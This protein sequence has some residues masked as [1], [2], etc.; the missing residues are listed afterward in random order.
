[1]SR[2]KGMSRDEKLQAIQD[3]MMETKDIYSLKDLEKELPKKKGISAMTVKDI[4]QEACE[5]DLVSFEKI[6]SGNY[7]WCFP[8]EALNRR[9]VVE[10]KYMEKIDALEK[11]IQELEKEIGEL[12]PGRED[13]SERT[14]LDEE[15][16]DFSRKISEVKRES[17]KYEKLNP[18][19]IRKQKEQTIVAKDAANRWTDNIFTIRSWVVKNFCMESSTFNQQFEIPD[20]FDYVE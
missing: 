12:E 5:N 4:L 1:M 7:Y 11:E 17:A 2:K 9:K 14:Q 6:G 3:L 10:Q 13:S 20:D 15:I 16:E 19:G 18:D 8:S